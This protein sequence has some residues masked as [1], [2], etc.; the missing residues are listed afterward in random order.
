MPLC[1]G[2]RHLDERAQPAG[3]PTRERSGR[4]V[5]RSGRWRGGRLDRGVEAGG[6][7]VGEVQALRGRAWNLPPGVAQLGV[8]VFDPADRGKGIGSAAVALLTGWLLEHAGAVR[9]QAGTA[10]GNA[11]MRGVFE[12]LGFTCEGVMRAFI[13]VVD[14]GAEFEVVDHLLGAGGPLPPDDLG[15]SVDLDRGHLLA[16]LRVWN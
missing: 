11:A 6:R 12:R 8:A 7:L 9:V 5:E 10:V 15:R 14:A 1:L 13:A 2:S 4:L 16:E 3:P